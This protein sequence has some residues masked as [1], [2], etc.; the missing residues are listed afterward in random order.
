MRTRPSTLP[1]ALTDLIRIEPLSSAGILHLAAG[2]GV[3][4]HVVLAENLDRL[5]RTPPHTLV[6]VH[7]EAASGG[8]SLAAAL[9]LAWERNLVGVV[10]P[11]SVAG[12]S[13]AALARRLNLC[14]LVIDDDPVEVA[15][16]LAGQ[17][18]SPDAA[19]A[20]RQALTAEQLAEQTGI[21]GVLKVL[22]D[23][24]APV[25]VALVAGRTLLAGRA[26]ALTPAVG[27][28]RMSVVVDGHPDAPELVAAI[29]AEM[30]AAAPQVEALLRLA[31]PAVLAG[32][33]RTRLEPAGQAVREA[34]GF[35]LLH[36]SAL[37]QGD[38]AS[39]AEPPPWSTDLGWQ[40]GEVNRAVWFAPV[41]GSGRPTPALS[42]LLRAGWQHGR[43]AWPLITQ[44]TGWVSWSSGGDPADTGPMRRALAAFRETAAVHDLAIGVGRAHPGTAGL[45]RSVDEARLAAHVARSQGSAA[46]QWFEQVGPNAALAWLPMAD[47]ADVARLCV[48]ELMAAPDHGVLVGTVLA[49]LNCGGALAEAAQRLGVHRNTVLAR[50]ARA[51]QLGLA[52]DDPDQR[53]AVHVLCHALAAANGQSGPTP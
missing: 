3:V 24:L 30:A 40:L 9:H 23:E 35:E 32:W 12:P 33:A 21:R 18:S 39:G 51:R 19:R 16:A 46:V 14:L 5:R 44:D 7:G 50:V 17:V 38:D 34:A 22:G 6:V 10:V 47:L 26:A 25:A 53:L 1:V 31:R 13:G 27:A 8:W 43:I 45:L 15:L 20:L 11:R 36:Q 49:V 29:P 41:P 4:L 28:L 37:V 48:P 42:Q 2:P 52:Y